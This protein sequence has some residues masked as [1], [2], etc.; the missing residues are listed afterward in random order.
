MPT[1]TTIRIGNVSG[2]TGDAPDAMLRMVSQGNIDAV[3]GDWLS[4]MNIA[5][6]AI[7]KES[8]P[9]LGYEAGFLHQLEDCIHI[10]AEQGIKVV[11]NAGALNTESLT[12]QVKELCQSKNLGY[13]NVVA[14]LGDDISELLHDEKVVES[15][16]HLDDVNVR[17]K[18]WGLVPRC[19]VAYIGA[20]GIV[21]A[22]KNGADIV[23]CGRVTDASPVIGLCAWWHD[24]SQDSFDELARALVA[25]HL[26]E[27]G[28]YATGANF[29]GFKERLLELIDLGFPIA[30]VDHKG[31]CTITKHKRS[32]G[33]VTKFNITAQLLYELQGQLYLNPDVV[34]DLTDISIEEEGEDRVRVTGVRGLAPP[35]TTK[36]MVCAVGGYQA[37][38]TFYINGLDVAEKAKMMENQ[39]RCHFRDNN[40]S[41]LA[42]DLYGSSNPDHRS[43]REGTCFLRVFAQAR[44]REDIEFKQFQRPIYALRM[45]SY[46]GYHMNLDFR[47]MQPKPF[48]ELFPSLIDLSRLNHRIVLADGREIPIPVSPRAIEYQIK[49]PSNETRDARSLESFGP[50]QRAPLGTIVHARSG[51]KANNSNVGFFVRHEDEYAWLQSFMTVERLKELF[52]DDWKSECQVERCEFEKI[53]AVHL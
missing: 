3:V 17:L 36:A 4:E 10:I 29:S 15:M 27:C 51:D 44:R 24:W 34:A 11:A 14:I 2:A 39:L 53:W 12:R 18:D 49:R 25:G 35:T 46:P 8:Q 45:Q 16:H 5:W 19:G 6:N 28:P 33:F 42:I 30:E 37:E 52:A 31:V 7:T 41:K 22:L 32:A 38:A 23:I 47:T 48:M 43:Q 26:I 40:F 9:D 13:L 50:M 21:E 1:R 20:W